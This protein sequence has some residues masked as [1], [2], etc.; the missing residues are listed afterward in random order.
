MSQRIEAIISGYI[1]FLHTELMVKKYRLVTTYKNN[2]LREG[3]LSC[4]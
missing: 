1:S 2:K 4:L 3:K